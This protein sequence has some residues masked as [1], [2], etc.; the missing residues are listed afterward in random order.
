MSVMARRSNSA[1][2]ADLA[3]AVLASAV[4][5]S[6]AE[7]L[8]MA[9][10]LTRLGI[11]FLA[12]VTFAASVRGTRASLFAALFSLLGYMFFLDLRA[13]EDTS[14]VETLLAVLIFLVVA[15]VTGTLAGQVHDEAANARRHAQSME[16]LFSTSRRL[17]EEDESRFWPILADTI[18][19]AS[20]GAALALDASGSVQARTHAAADD[21]EAVELGREMLGSSTTACPVSKGPWRARTVPLKP[22]AAGV[23]LWEGQDQGTDEFVE[24]LGDL[25]AAS[26]AR[27]EI[28]R[29]QTRAR[30]SEE[31]SK[32]RQ[33]LLSSISHDFRSPLA[34][35]IGSSTSLLEYGHKFDDAVRHDL[36]LNIRDEGEK[37]NQFVANLL[38]MTRLQ[39]GVV[40]PACE[41]LFM[42][43]VI[44]AAVERLGRHRGKLPRIEVD[45][46]CEV[47]ADPLLLEQALYNVLDN[48]AKYADQGGAI[49][50]GCVTRE[51][52]SRIVIADHGPGLPVEDHAGIFETFHF[53]RKSG[54]AKGTGLGLSISRGFVEAMG[55]TIEARNR[56][57]GQSGLEIAIHLPRSGSC[58][59]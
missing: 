21:T 10:G 18:S 58:G 56:S 26:L 4:A 47:D 38:N 54:Q 49:E 9:L 25:A 50:I 41:R 5:L 39:A 12:A 37:L 46:A 57:D 52:S 6:A 45:A 3:A 7:L 31:A 55:G 23:L 34:A 15:L 33:A 35:I 53:A 1:F 28:R 20:G 36:L 43:D 24:V 8:Y 51:A 19:K 14:A 48:A 13:G 44:N 59:S 27:S 22:P 17:S 30:A 29:E 32:L 2:S 11:L 42:D 40:Q 16:L